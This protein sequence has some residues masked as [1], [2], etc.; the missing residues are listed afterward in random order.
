MFRTVRALLTRV[1]QLRNYAAI[2]AG[3]EESLPSCV[4][5][6]LQ[7]LE[8]QTRD[9]GDLINSM[10]YSSAAFLLARIKGS[11]GPMQR[12]RGSQKLVKLQAVVLILILEWPSSFSTYG[13]P[14]LKAPAWTKPRVKPSNPKWTWPM[15][16]MIL[17]L[18]ASEPVPRRLTLNAFAG[19][20]EGSNHHG[21]GRYEFAPCRA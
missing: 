15:S 18:S 4:M 16:L 7:G 20:L 11:I 13:S 2:R 5:R 10:A 9:M 14:S 6:V 12:S 8:G 3:Q 17:S 1:F 19:G 21:A